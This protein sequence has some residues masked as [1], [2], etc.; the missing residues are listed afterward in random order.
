[1][2]AKYGFTYDG[3]ADKKSKLAEHAALVLEARFLNVVEDTSI[4]TEYR[5]KLIQGLSAK[6][7]EY[8][9]KYGVD[10]KRLVNQKL[11]AESLNKMMNRST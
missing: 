11:L 8:S 7:A 10:M 6:V 5:R 9:T 4:T 2:A 3:L 1:M